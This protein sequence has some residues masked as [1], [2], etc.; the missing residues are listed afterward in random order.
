MP[1][2]INARKAC[3]HKF[4]PGLS[5]GDAPRPKNAKRTL[6]TTQAAGLPPLYL[7]LTEVGDTLTTQIWQ[8]EPNLNPTQPRSTPISQNEP[9]LRL[10]PHHL[11]PVHPHSAKRTQFPPPIALCLLPV[12]TKRTQFPNPRCFSYFLLS[13]GQ[14]PAQSNYHTTYN[15]QSS[16]FDPC[17][18]HFGLFR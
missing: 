1:N 2:K 15:T 14:R 4:N 7:T 8:N 12:S 13:H 16:F 18:A 11:P 6:K 5:A 9:N 10:A 3:L 17:T